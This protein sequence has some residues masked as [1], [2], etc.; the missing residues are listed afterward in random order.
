MNYSKNIL[1]KGLILFAVI[2]QMHAVLNLLIIYEKQ[3]IDIIVLLVRQNLIIH[4][5]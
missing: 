4:C 3:K 2:Y 1:L 5:K